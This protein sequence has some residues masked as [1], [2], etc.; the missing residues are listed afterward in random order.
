[1]LLW[2]TFFL[3]LFNFFWIVIQDLYKMVGWGG[4]QKH[5][6]DL[7]VIDHEGEII[8]EIKRTAEYGLLFPL[9]SNTNFVITGIEPEREYPWQD[10]DMIE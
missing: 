9:S 3:T 7:R 4:E 10:G 2:I 1:M 5:R 6:I 8:E